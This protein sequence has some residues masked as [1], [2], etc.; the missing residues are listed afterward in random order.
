MSHASPSLPLAGC[1][2]VDL[3]IIT[4]GASTSALLADLGA[5]VIKIESASYPDPFRDWEG[6]AA[7][8]AAWNASP[9]YRFT[10]RNKRCVSLDLKTPHGSEITL[11]LV[12]EADVVV[13]NFRRGVMER[14]GLAYETLRAANPRVILASI[15]SQGDTGPER[16]TASFGSTLEATGGLAY[17]TG[18]AGGG[19]VI[20]GRDLNYPDQVVSLISAGFVVAALIEAR[21]TGKGAHLDISQRELTSFLIGEEILAA[22]SRPDEA[23]SRTRAGN[24]DAA[25]LFQ[26]CVAGSDGWLA[27]TIPDEAAWERVA[28]ATGDGSL[29]ERLAAWTRRLPVNEAARI[30]R[31]AGIAAARVRD[32]EAIAADDGDLRGAALARAPTGEPV[33][34]FPFQ[35][36]DAPFEIVRPAPD[37]GAHTEAVLRELLG[38]SA[39]ELAELERTG[40]TARVPRGRR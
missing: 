30:L 15:S 8:G 31:G 14:M 39:A 10:N 35:R 23:S 4:A 5:D 17:L 7:D 37:L 26:E 40:V 11:A 9:L 24:A 1:R 38:I 19:P 25:T 20:S 28:A 27:V 13:E 32:G 16:A 21:R 33:K 3:G 34:G 18:Y 29:P 36:R 2:V 12:R 22:G 6:T